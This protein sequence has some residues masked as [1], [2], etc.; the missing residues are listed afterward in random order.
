[1]LSVFSALLEMFLEMDHVDTEVQDDEV[2]YTFKT[3]SLVPA[4]TK[5]KAALLSVADFPVDIPSKI[6]VEEIKRG[7]LFKEYLVKIHVPR[8]GIGKIRDLI[9]VR[10]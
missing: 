5:I 9:R 4:L 7:V 1:M 6:E 2:I 3:T 10:S 8:E